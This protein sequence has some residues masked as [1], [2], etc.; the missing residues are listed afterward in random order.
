LY[1]LLPVKTINDYY[2][3]VT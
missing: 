2:A 1:A 3:K